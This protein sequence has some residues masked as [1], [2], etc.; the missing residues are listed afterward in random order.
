M[1]RCHGDEH[2]WTLNHDWDGGPSEYPIVQCRRC[3]QCPTQGQLLD[4]V[5]LGRVPVDVARRLLVPPSLVAN[6]APAT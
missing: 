2:D 3:G 1:K 6:E 4:L 5:D